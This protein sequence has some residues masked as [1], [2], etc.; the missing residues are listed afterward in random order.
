MKT[1]TELS[2]DEHVAKL[3]NSIKEAHDAVRKHLRSFLRS[4]VGSWIEGLDGAV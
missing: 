1:S 4:F 2:P 3:Q